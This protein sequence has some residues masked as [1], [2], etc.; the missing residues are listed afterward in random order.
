MSTDSREERLARR[1]AELYATD[2]QFAE[3]RPVEA[4]TAA[5]EHPGLRLPRIMSTV[6]RAYAERPA[7]GERAVNLTTDP[8]TGR[9]SLELLP[10]FETITYLEL[11]KRVAAVARALT[12]GPGQPVQPGDRVCVL[13]FASADYATIDMALVQVGAV[14]VPLQTSAPVSQ[15]QPIVA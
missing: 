14:S 6:M 9:T 2:T 12:D 4:L 15:L 10:W 11:W 8:E 1:V 7:L 3:A 5:I 13:G